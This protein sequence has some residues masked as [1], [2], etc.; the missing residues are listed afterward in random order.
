[1]WSLAG[2]WGCSAEEPPPLEDVTEAPQG[3]SEAEVRVLL[4]L[5]DR[6]AVPSIPSYNPL[7]RE[8]I[9]LGRYL[10]YDARLS[11]NE[12]QSCASCHAQELAFADGLRAPVGSTGELL[13]RNSPGLAN[14]A[15][16][17]TFTWAHPALRSLEE[18]LPVPILGDNPVE[19]GV[20]DGSREAVLARFD[21]DAGYRRRFA[22]AFPQSESGATVDKI[23]HALASFCR[24]LLS[25]DSPYDRYLAGEK[26]ALNAA[27]R[28][29]LGLFSG[30]RL[31]C[32]HC[33]SGTN[34]T[35]SY[36]DARTTEETARHPFFNDGLYDL[37]GRGAYPPADQGL[38]EVTLDPKDRGLFRP[39]S[40]RNIA[41]TAPYM[42]DGSIEDLRGVLA[43]YA[44]GGTVTES[45]PLAGD[46]R[47]SPLKSGLLRG[48]KLS[49]QETE[50]VLAFFEALTDE[51]FITNPAFASPFSAE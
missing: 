17:S 15:Y 50:D 26:D 30:E 39:P 3:P 37:D 20:S 22:E 9:E 42:H 31:E 40:L 13:H 7:S 33:H 38:Y 19:L 36:R 28:R 11:T 45:G 44:A 27:Q 5:P 51:G 1:M 24:S 18:Q 10:F 8:K 21:A 48:F 14:V 29:G 6:F 12:T 16:F 49:E 25:H 34:L 32:F 47:S 23:V 4:D 41:L 43:H 2:L 35:V 46:G